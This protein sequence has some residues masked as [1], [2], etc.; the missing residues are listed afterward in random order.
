MLSRGVVCALGR[1][2]DSARDHCLQRWLWAWTGTGTT[3][4]FPPGKLSVLCVA[5][6]GPFAKASIKLARHNVKPIRAFS[7]LDEFAK[8]SGHCE[9]LH[10][11]G[12]KMPANLAKHVLVGSVLAASCLSTDLDERGLANDLAGSHYEHSTPIYRTTGSLR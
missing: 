7:T 5:E 6:E 2:A 3:R 12:V 4:A 8:G 9:I 10:E 11:D 1:R